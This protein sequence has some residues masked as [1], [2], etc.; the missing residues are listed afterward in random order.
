MK[1]NTTLLLF[2]IFLFVCC[3]ANKEE[4]KVN[5]DLITNPISLNSDIS[6]VDLPIL[7]VEYDSFDFGNVIQGEQVS[8]TFIVKNTGVR[9]L[10]INSARGSCGCTVPEWTK[11]PIKKNEEAAVKVT[12][13]SSGRSGKQKKNITLVTNSIPNTKI[14]TISCDVIVKK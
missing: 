3:D 11:N 9:P 12:F 13:D 6:D 5:S 8:H 2:V 7:F 10:I 1:I 14:L 4:Q